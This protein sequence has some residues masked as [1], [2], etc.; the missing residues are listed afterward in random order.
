MFVR[1]Y[2]TLG[3]NAMTLRGLLN[4]HIQRLTRCKEETT[5]YTEREQPEVASE[6]RRQAEFHERAIGVLRS[7]ISL[8]GY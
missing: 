4:W 1:A 6:K 8:S 7:A 2:N 5:E 3:D